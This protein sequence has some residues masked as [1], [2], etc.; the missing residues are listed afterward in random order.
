MRKFDY[1]RLH[2]QS[3]DN[4]TLNFIANIS[5]MQSRQDFCETKTS[6]T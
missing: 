5:Q 1:S 3:W 4:K 2:E 6:G